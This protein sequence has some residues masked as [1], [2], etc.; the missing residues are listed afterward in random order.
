MAKIRVLVVDDDPAVL[1]S[2]A[3]ALHH[4]GRVRTGVQPLGDEQLGRAVRDLIYPWLTMIDHCR[5]VGILRI[6]HKPNSRRAA[7]E[8]EVDGH[9]RVTQP[10]P[11]GIGGIDPADND[12]A[13]VAGCNQ[14][15]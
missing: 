10:R 4:L 1:D 11:V 12:D 2:V 15:L 6:A 7:S 14:L 13:R 3:G 5:D 8:A 9:A